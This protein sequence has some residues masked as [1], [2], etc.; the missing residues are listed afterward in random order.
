MADDTHVA[1]RIEQLGETFD[2]PLTLTIQQADGRIQQVPVVVTTPVHEALVPV[3]GPV[4]RL[5]SRDDAGLVSVK[6]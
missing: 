6:R 5:D 4:R 3:T 1:V 2:F